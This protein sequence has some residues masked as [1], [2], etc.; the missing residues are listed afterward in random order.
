MV[1]KQTEY[2]RKWSKKQNIN[3]LCIWCKN[4][5]LEH[6]K[7]CEMCYFKATAQATMKNR[8]LAKDLQDL[9]YLQGEKC[10]ITGNKLVLGLN[11]GLDHLEPNST[12]PNLISDITNVRWVDRKINEMKRDWTIDEFIDM[13]K[14]VAERHPDGIDL[15]ISDD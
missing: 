7:L 5:K 15:S 2:N 10:F 11:A 6:S 14:V 13:C 1:T 8:K 12:S 9:F 4:E 3:G